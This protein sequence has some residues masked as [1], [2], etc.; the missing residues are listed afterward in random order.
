MAYSEI[1]IEFEYLP[2]RSDG[3]RITPRPIKPESNIQRGDQVGGIECMRASRLREAF[4][5]ATSV[6]QIV[7]I[8]LSRS[9]ITRTQRYGKLKFLLC[10]P[11]IPFVNLPNHSA[12]RVSFG[13][14]LI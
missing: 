13:T 1:R 12:G 7:A 4:L 5:D 9:R 8:P 14:V 11:P 2:N 10:A 3:F 6:T